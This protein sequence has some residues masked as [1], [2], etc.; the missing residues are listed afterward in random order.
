MFVISRIG[1]KVPPLNADIFE[2]HDEI[3]TRS[4]KFLADARTAT[5]RKALLRNVAEDFSIFVSV[6]LIFNEIESNFNCVECEAER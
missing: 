6:D 5:N 3:F 4:F 1:I 2:Q